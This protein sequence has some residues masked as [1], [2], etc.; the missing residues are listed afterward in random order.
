MSQIGFWT[1]RKYEMSEADSSQMM[2][3]KAVGH[4]TLCNEA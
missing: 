1:L 3:Y 4:M 2:N